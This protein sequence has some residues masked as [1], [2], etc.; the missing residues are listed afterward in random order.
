M[1][2]GL[3]RRAGPEASTRPSA[4]GTN[5][6]HPRCR[7]PGPPGVSEAGSPAGWVVDLSEP[8][9]PTAAADTSGGA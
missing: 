5:R 2:Q 4:R 9:T 8:L 7:A 3:K 1:T 6:R